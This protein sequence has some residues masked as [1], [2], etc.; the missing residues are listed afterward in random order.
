LQNGP[1]ER[2]IDAVHE[3]AE[4]LRH[5][6]LV[7]SLSRSRAAEEHDQ[8]IQLLEQHRIAEVAETMHRHVYTGMP[9]A[10]ETVSEAEAG[11]SP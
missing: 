4:P 9:A 10:L 11:G 1:L 2:A 6:L 5:A 8:I 7:R 3:L